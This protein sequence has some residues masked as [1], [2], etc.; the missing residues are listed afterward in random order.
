MQFHLALMWNLIRYKLIWS[1]EMK[2]EL[3]CLN[4]YF[5]WRQGL[6][7]L[8]SGYSTNYRFSAKNVEKWFSRSPILNWFLFLD[9]MSWL[10][11]ARSCDS[12]GYSEEKQPILNKWDAM[13]WN[14]FY[15]KIVWL[16]PK[17][18]LI[19]FFLHFRNISTRR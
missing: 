13:H 4:H 19:W 5:N 9:C 8:A 18:N 7:V 6:V 15:S 1:V 10:V 16:F 2:S 17:I 3:F 12:C 14:E 11:D